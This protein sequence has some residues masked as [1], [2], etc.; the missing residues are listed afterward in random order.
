[1]DPLSLDAQNWS[2]A[3]PLRAAID[4]ASRT[5]DLGLGT[6]REHVYNLVDAWVAEIPCPVVIGELER[7]QH[8][9]ERSRT[10]AYQERVT[11]LYKALEVEGDGWVPKERYED[12]CAMSDE[13]RLKWDKLEARG[14]YP[15]MDG[16]PSWFVGS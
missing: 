10:R 11:R 5:W 9:E 6:L 13:K 4:E 3:V 8:S 7:Q 14:A 16:A 2:R 15:L 12:A 1:M